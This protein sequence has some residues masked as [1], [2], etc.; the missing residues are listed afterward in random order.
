LENIKITLKKD[1]S[2]FLPSFL[3]SFHRGS[4]PFA[5]CSELQM[6]LRATRASET[7]AELTKLAGT[8]MQTQYEYQRGEM[9]VCDS[10]GY[11]VTKNQCFKSNGSPAVA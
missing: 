1:V 8:H 6:R 10:D 4:F 2:F 11:R 3:L 7:N 9:K 5:K